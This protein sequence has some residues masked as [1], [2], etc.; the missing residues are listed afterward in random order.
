MTVAFRTCPLCEA[1]CGLALEV[2][3]AAHTLTKVRGDAD[4]VFSKGF[5]CPKG[6]SIKELHDDPDR[7]RTPLVKQPDGSFAAVSWDEAFGEIGRRLPPIIQA[8][9][10]AAEAAYI[11]NPAAH[12]LAFLLYGKVLLKALGSKNIFSASTVDQYPKQAASALMFGT[13]TTIA[14]PDLDRTD[15]L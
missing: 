7:V 1:T 2:D 8:G 9:G 5:I 12:S 4:D 10:R 15:Y 13:G 14:I 3:A 6:V 11:G